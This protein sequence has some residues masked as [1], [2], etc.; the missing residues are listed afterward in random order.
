VPDNPSMHREAVVAYPQTQRQD[1]LAE[2]D[3]FE[4]SDDLVSIAGV[5]VCTGVA[6]TLGRPR[7]DWEV[8][9]L[10]RQMSATNPR[11]QIFRGG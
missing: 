7:A 10:I 4:P 11:V 1:S 9:D 6:F 5:S 3:E 2:R 8:R